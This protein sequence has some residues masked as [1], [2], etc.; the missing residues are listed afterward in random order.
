[1]KLWI[2][3]RVYFEPLA[4]EYPI[5]EKIFNFCKKNNIEIF[6]TTSHNQVRGI[7]GSTEKAKFANA[8]KTLV[9]GRKKSL[10]LLVLS[11]YNHYL[12]TRLLFVCVLPLIDK[13]YQKRVCV[14]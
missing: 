7:P 5:G 11:P 10:K 13:D 3:D 9:V 14:V 12:K 6:K 8:K 4:I 1:M 2:P